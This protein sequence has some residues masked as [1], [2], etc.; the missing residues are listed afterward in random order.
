MDPCVP[1]ASLDNARAIART[2]LGVPAKYANKM[3]VPAI[4]KAL[5]LSHKTNIMPPMDYRKFEGKTYLIDPRSPLSIKDFIILFGNSPEEQIQKIAK[6]LE[7][8]SNGISKS[9]L[10]SNIFKVLKALNVYE[11]IEIPYHKVGQVVQQN[12]TILNQLPPSLNTNM[13]QTQLPQE[14]ELGPESGE[15]P[16]NINVA[17]NFVVPKARPSKVSITSPNTSPNTNFWKRYLGNYNSPSPTPSIRRVQPSRVSVPTGTQISQNQIN[18]DM[19]RI[20][21]LRKQIG[22]TTSPNE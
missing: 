8:V 1:G 3:S 5:K 14:Q 20:E 21:N 19:K 10:K 16:Y 11:P 15:Y 6:K 9:E 12:N 22:N 18:E 2:R 17:P 4:C 13:N 7:L